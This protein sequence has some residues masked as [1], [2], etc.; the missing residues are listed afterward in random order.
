MQNAYMLKGKFGLVLFFKKKNAS[1]KSSH[2]LKLFIS[3]S[4]QEF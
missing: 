2:F 1:W 4:A 3:K